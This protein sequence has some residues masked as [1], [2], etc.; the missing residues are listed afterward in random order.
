MNPTFHGMLGGQELDSLTRT[1]LL[2]NEACPPGKIRFLG[3]GEGGLNL[4][5]VGK[6]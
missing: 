3:G 6:L 1:I 2:E 4:F 5:E